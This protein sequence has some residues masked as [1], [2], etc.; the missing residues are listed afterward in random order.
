MIIFKWKLQVADSQTIYAPT[1]AKL[2]TTQIQ[3]GDIQLWALCDEKSPTEPRRIAV[4]GTGNLI[5]ESSP[6]EYIGTVQF[7]GG[8]LVFHI[9]ELLGE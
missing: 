2:L 5:G 7:H 6:G 9:F 4:Y 3:N 1:G 8:A